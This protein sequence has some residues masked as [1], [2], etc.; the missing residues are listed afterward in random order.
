MKP[1]SQISSKLIGIIVSENTFASSGHMICEVRFDSCA[2]GDI[3][4]PDAP[5]PERGSIK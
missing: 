4:C 3:L 2:L 1:G 5:G